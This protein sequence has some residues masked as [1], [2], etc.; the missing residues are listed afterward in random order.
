MKQFLAVSN[1][2]LNYHNCVIFGYF[3]H[4]QHSEIAWAVILRGDRLNNPFEGAH[5]CGADTDERV[6]LVWPLPPHRV[7]TAIGRA[8]NPFLHQ[9]GRRYREGRLASPLRLAG[10]ENI[11]ASTGSARLKQDWRRVLRSLSSRQMVHPCCSCP[12]GQGAADLTRSGTLASPAVQVQGC[13]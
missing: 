5:T 2:F 13:S 4:R 3:R 8:P 9:A 6:V 11:A 1:R 10:P 7:L 12:A